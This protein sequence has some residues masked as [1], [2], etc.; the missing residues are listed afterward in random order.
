V[1]AS[2]FEPFNTTHVAGTGLGL[3]IAREFCLA[4]RCRLAY[5]ELAMPDGSLRRGFVV[6]F[7]DAD[8]EQQGS[9]F[10]DT[11]TPHE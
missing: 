8:G 2:L 1:R 11:M 5:D 6:R 3:F 9:D 10:L 4:N 7:T